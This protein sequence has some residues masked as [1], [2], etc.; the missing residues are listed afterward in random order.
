VKNTQPYIIAGMTIIIVVLA[1]YVYSMNSD[2]EI[3]KKQIELSKLENDKKQVQKQASTVISELS[4]KSTQTVK[5]GNLIIKKV[6]Y[7]TPK[8]SDTTG[9]YML[10]YIRNYRPE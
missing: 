4:K 8:I 3:Y 1:F 9:I 2:V 5:K 6:T 10:E 7:E